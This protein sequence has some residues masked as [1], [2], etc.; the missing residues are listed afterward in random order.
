MGQD[1]N[2]DRIRPL[3]VHEPRPSEPH[4]LSVRAPIPKTLPKTA[5]ISGCGLR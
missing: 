4:E 2:Y 3:H 1:I 5:W